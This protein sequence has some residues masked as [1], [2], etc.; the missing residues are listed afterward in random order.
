[1]T[2]P[3]PREAPSASAER[4]APVRASWSKAVASRA[5]KGVSA[6]RATDTAAESRRA[7]HPARAASSIPVAIIEPTISLFLIA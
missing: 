3:E 5:A 1:M 4:R 6:D 7:E 2:S